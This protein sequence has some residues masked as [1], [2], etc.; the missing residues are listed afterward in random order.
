MAGTVDLEVA[1]AVAT[2]TFDN[3]EK[4]NALGPPLINDIIGMLDEVEERDDVRC[5]VLT[6]AGE[7]AFSSGFDISY[8][9]RNYG[10]GP[11][12]T[13]E[14][15]DFSEMSERVKNFDYPTIAMINGGTFG[16]AM[17]LISCCD[18]RIAVEGAE[19]GIT[20]ARLGLV[21]EGDAIGQ[22]MLHVGPANIKEFLF[23][24]DFVDAERAS[25]MGLV[26]YV[27][28]RDQLEA[29]TYD[30]AG[31]IASNA[32]L[33]LIK[34]KKIVGALNEHQR[35]TETET[36]WSHMLREEAKASRDHQEGV[37]A[38]MED[39]DPEFEGR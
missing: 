30:M 8:H 14:E 21:Y 32:P 17:H 20:P 4:R 3:R 33:S 29:K 11:E 31:S 10:E 23:T 37:E 38:F 1:D 34:M 22:V 39:R 26:N 27:V 25:D 9:Q 12:V 24:A 13:E 35:L 6:G 19:F 28:E 16:G 15:G 2:I 7:K 36:E 5:L 18:L